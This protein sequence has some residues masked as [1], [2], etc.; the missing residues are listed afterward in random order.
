MNSV[1]RTMGEASMAATVTLPPLTV[2]RNEVAAEGVA[3]ELATAACT[4]LAAS[5]VAARI[6]TERITLPG[7]TVTITSVAGTPA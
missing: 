5:V 6:L 7:A 2:D 4:V 3:T 1:E